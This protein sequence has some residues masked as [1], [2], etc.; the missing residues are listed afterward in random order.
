MS[1]KQVIKRDGRVV[2]FDESKIKV[3]IQRA[4]IATEKG[5]DN[6][7]IERI[8]KSISSQV[9]NKTHIEDIQEMVEFKLMGSNRKDVAQAYIR[10]R[11]ERTEYRNKV[12]K[13]DKK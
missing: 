9:K 7:L 5:V 2:D 8:S 4:M 6:D 12:N 3:A 11:N 13:L 1:V 10:Y